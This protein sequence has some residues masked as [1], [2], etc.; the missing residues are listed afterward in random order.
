MTRIKITGYVESD[1]LDPEHVDLT[2]S[3]GLTEDG[4]LDLVAGE[5]GKPLKLTDL[6]DVETEVVR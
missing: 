6:D 2:H 3:T 5:Q 1:D 4:Y